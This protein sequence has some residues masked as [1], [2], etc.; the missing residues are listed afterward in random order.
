MDSVDSNVYRV[1]TISIC[2]QLR[3]VLCYWGLNGRCKIFHCLQG[4]ALATTDTTGYGGERSMSTQEIRRVGS[5]LSIINRAKNPPNRGTKSGQIGEIGPRFGGGGGLCD[6]S[7]TA[8][9]KVGSHPIFQKSK[10]FLCRRSGRLVPTTSHVVVSKV[11]LSARSWQRM[12]IEVAR[13]PRVRTHSEGADFSAA[14]ARAPMPQV[15]F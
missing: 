4:G 3:M 1:N 5:V 11:L 6:A 14:S 13:R 12:C 8:C 15:C 9:A 7:A 2:S 10:G